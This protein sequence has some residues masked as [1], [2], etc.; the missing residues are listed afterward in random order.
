MNL[1]KPM[2]NAAKAFKVGLLALVLPALAQAAPQPLMQSAKNP[3]D[4]FNP[5]QKQELLQDRAIYEY[6]KSD[7][8]KGYGQA[9]IIINAPV[10]TCFVIFSKLDQQYQYFPRKTKSEVIK[11]EGNTVWL[12]NEF[13]FYIG[14]VEYTSRYTIDRERRRF[15]FEMDKSYPHNIPESAGYFV[16]EKIDDQRTLFTYAATRLDTGYQ[17]PQVVQNFIT[18]RDLPAQAINV[19]KRIE[20]GG[21]WTTAA[22]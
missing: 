9:E 17:V 21:K 16:F 6:K 14:R 20:S 8:G 1:V 13:Y 10:E 12:H 18:S 2:K 11:S 4:S 22:Q 19:K 15:D 7:N 3:L 5:S